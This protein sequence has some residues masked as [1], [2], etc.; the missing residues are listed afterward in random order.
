MARNIDLSIKQQLVEKCLMVVLQHGMADISLRTLAAEV[1]T[2][3][4][5]LVYHFG[6]ADALFVEM[7]KAF[8][9]Q[10]K[11]GFQALLEE[12]KPGQTVGEFFQRHWQLFLADRYKPIFTLFF[13]LYVRSL[14]DQETYAFFFDD[15]LHEWLALMERTLRER[16]GVTADAPAWA[17]LIVTTARGLLFDWL[18]SGE[19]E[20]IRQAIGV[21]KDMLDHAIS[22]KS[23]SLSAASS[24]PII[25]T[26]APHTAT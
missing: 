20:R 22:K 13:E 8:S 7:I 10:E 11:L 4:R 21:F 15:V 6:S 5:M 24:G 26:T 23:P 18:A 12:Q 9:R 3:A 17:T 16:Y 25:P 2:S 19:T 1:G 14:R